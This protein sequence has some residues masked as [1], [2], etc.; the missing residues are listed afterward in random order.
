MAKSRNRK[1]HKQKV[2]ARNQKIK[3]MRNRYGKYQ[4]MMIEEMIKKEQEKGL[5]DDAKLEQD[6]NQI[7]VDGPDMG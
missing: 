2:A 3:D 4:K 7:I 6:P 1:G 5:F